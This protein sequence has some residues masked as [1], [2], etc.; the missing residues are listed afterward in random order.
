MCPLQL[1][2]RTFDKSRREG[3][4]VERCGEAAFAAL[5]PLAA[6]ARRPDGP[7]F[8]GFTFVAA[9]A[10]LALRVRDRVRDG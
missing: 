9:R 1:T 2:W 8:A 3:V 10:W 5:A 7:L 6:R 4:S